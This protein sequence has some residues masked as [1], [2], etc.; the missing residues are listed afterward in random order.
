SLGCDAS[1]TVRAIYDDGSRGAVC[2]ARFDEADSSGA[3]LQ[4]PIKRCLWFELEFSGIGKFI[5][6]SMNLKFYRGSEI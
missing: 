5:L 2:G 3:S 1:F 6:K 4:L